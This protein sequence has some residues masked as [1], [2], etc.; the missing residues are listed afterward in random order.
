MKQFIL[1]TED[2]NTQLRQQVTFHGG[3]KKIFYLFTELTSRDTNHLYY[4][5][6]ENLYEHIRN[7][8]K[9][10]R[11]NFLIRNGIQRLEKP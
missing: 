6:N 4:N 5:Y 7:S 9:F 3:N 2:K 10:S 1:Q 8:F 11:V